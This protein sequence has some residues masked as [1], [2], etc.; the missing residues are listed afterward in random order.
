VSMAKLCRYKWCRFPSALG[1]PFVLAVGAVLAWAAPPATRPD[2]VAPDGYISLFNGEDLTG[3][4]GRVGDPSKRAALSPA[5]LM[6]AQREADERMRAHWQ[7]VDGALAFDG[8]GDNLCTLRQFTDFELLLDWKIEAG[9]DSGVYLRGYPQVQIWDKPEGSGGLWNNKR[10]PAQPLIFADRPVG[11][12]N[13]FRIFMIGD[14]VTVYLNDLL[15]VDDTP[16]ENYWEPDQPLYP[17]GPIELQSHGTRV[18]FKNIYVRELVRPPDISPP[19]RPLLRPGD[20]VAIVGDSITEQKLY[21]RYMEDY[22]LACVPQLEL[23]VV[24]LGWSGER[25]PGFFERLDND[26]FPLKPTVV[27]TCYGMNDGLYKPYEPATGQAYEQAMRQ[28]IQRLRNAGIRVVVGAPGAVDFDTFRRVNLSPPV[29][30]ATLAQLRDV[31]RLLAY[32]QGQPFATVHDHMILAMRRAKPVLGAE[33]HV[34][35]PDG[36]HPAPNGHVVMAYAFLK[37]LGLDGHI[38]TITVD[39]AAGTPAATASEGH[40]VLAAS[41]DGIQVESSRYPFCFYGDPTRPD[42][43]RS[44]L[45]FIPFNADLNRFLLVVRNLPA[46]AATVTWGEQSK[47]F[48]REQLQAGINLAAEFLDN[49]FSG[50]F[51][52]LDEL[53]AKK[54]AFE[55]AMIKQCIST[56]RQ[57]RSLFGDDPEVEAATAMLRERLLR[58]HE[59]WQADVRDAVV[60]VRHTLKIQPENE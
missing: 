14:R 33:Y 22:L 18:W 60:P 28:I 40:K 1:V 48:R 4:G 57:Y 2:N 8:Q 44:I 7:V 50:P 49:P 47:R 27:T 11:E 13:T 21:S 16:L 3:W 35:G 15:V 55:T 29:Y 53:V 20:R 6:R 23:S 34:C 5:Q 37:A 43:T 56:F 54:Q 10:H 46:A 59:Q 52:A 24:Q 58:I 36:F 9:S 12:W 31:A 42:G 39:W 17:R 19:Q 30:N 25:A 45:P 26:L 51:Q 32:E 41:A 38:G